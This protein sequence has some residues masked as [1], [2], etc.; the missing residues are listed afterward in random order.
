[1]KKSILGFD[2]PGLHGESIPLHRGILA[3]FSKK[4]A[5]LNQELI[6]SGPSSWNP[7]ER[8]QKAPESLGVNPQYLVLSLYTLISDSHDFL[9]LVNPPIMFLTIGHKILLP[10]KGL[11]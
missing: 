2:N 5:E 10:L 8:A 9:I 7:R 6:G 11:V 4:V 3:K 1:M